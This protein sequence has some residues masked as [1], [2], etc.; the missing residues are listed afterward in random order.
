VLPRGAPHRGP[1]AVLG[2][3]DAETTVRPSVTGNRDRSD[4]AEAATLTYAILLTAGPALVLFSWSFCQIA[5]L[6]D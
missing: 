2:N 5:N 1:S 4:G 3:R 6:V